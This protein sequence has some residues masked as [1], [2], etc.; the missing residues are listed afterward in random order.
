MQEYKFDQK[1]TEL[2]AQQ[3]EVDSCLEEICNLIS[4]DGGQNELKSCNNF[5]NKKCISGDAVPKALGVMDTPKTMDVVFAGVKGKGKILLLT[6]LKFKQ[7]NIDKHLVNSLL[8]KERKTKDFFNGWGHFSH[9][10]LANDE[11]FQR[12]KNTLSK[13][14]QP[15]AKTMKVLTLQELHD[16]YF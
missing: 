1:E 9:V 15:K 11:K 12:K 7:K 4:N 13:Y 3:L 16:C 2:L 5:K 10:I 14:L 6:E 8:E